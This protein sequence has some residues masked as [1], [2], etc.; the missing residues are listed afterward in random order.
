MYQYLENNWLRWYYDDDPT[1][2]FRTSKDQIFNVDFNLDPTPAQDLR[3]EMIRACHSI[4][5]VYPTETFS[6]MF[7][8]GSE[9]EMMVRAFFEAKIPFDIYIA[10]YANDLNIYDVSYAVITC[11]NLNL[12]YKIIDIDHNKFFDNELAEYSA[13]AEMNVPS[14][15]AVCAAI[16]K[17]DGLPILANGD[18]CIMRRPFYYDGR[19]SMWCN[20]EVEHD[21]GTAKH[22]LKQNRPAVTEFFRW[23]HRLLK[24][25]GTTKWFKDLVT[26]QIYGKLGTHSS[27]MQGYQEVWPELI[28]RRKSWGME[29]ILPHIQELENKLTTINNGIDFNQSQFDTIDRVYFYGE[30]QSCMH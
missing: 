25:V 24:S 9:S 6:L 14:I 2:I 12:K 11:E 16:D 4:R 19:P 30:N 1:Q 27:K 10:R 13:H 26:N 5:D 20:V 7:S 29:N 3:T 28:A 23:N 8:G 18:A 17:I 15:L 22:F 21:Y